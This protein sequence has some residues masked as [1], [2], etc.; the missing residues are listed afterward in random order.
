[1]RPVLSRRRC[2]EWAAASHSLL[3]KDSQA[4][5]ATFWKR[6]WKAK[7]RPLLGA[8]VLAVSVGISAKKPLQIRR[9]ARGNLAMVSPSTDGKGRAA[10]GK[11]VLERNFRTVCSRLPRVNGGTPFQTH[12]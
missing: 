12:I 7:V 11:E 6:G 1:M 5:W 8:W 2:M 3:A 4:N 9:P 10:L